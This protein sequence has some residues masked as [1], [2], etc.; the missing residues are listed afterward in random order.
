M[1]LRKINASEISA[2]L[3]CQRA[4]WYQQKG[5]ETENIT[6]LADG[7]NLHEEH[8]RVVFSSG[9]MRAAAYLI[10]LLSLVLFLIHLMNS[11]L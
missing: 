9:V 4:W 2:Y 6:E 7:H 10:L 3:Y 8:G 11:V 5:F 1:S